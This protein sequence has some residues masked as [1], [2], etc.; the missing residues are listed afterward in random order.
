MKEGFA[1][2]E[3]SVFIKLLVAGNINLIPSRITFGRYCR[4]KSITM[5][6]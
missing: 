2:S 1:G 5:T 4:N 3:L 6:A